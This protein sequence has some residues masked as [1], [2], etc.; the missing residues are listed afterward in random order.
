MSGR[1]WGTVQDKRVDCWPRV[2][3]LLLALLCALTVAT[4][5]AHPSG[6]AA[7]STNPAAGTD[8]WHDADYRPQP[9]Q[10][11]PYVL[12]PHGHEVLP[13]AV[14]SADPRGGAIQ[15]DPRAALG[16]TGGAVRLVSTGDRTTS[17]LLTLDFDK[18]VGGKI[19]VRVAGTSASAPI[20]HVCFSESR[21][22]MALRP[23]DNSG[24]ASYAPG[25][26]TA[27]IWNGYPGVSYTYDSDSH[28]VPLDGVPR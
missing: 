24:E 3:V 19:Q 23:Q 12:A 2:V 27:N 11:Q 16:N 8:P 15:G 5:F 26:D 6:A 25:C 17:P 7:A 10:W 18:D 13:V 20:L 28:L 9:G 14:L 4:L 21:Q 1:Q 22:F